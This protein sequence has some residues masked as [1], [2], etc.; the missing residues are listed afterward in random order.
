M[1]VVVAPCHLQPVE[2]LAEVGGFL[3]QGTFAG[4]TSVSCGT[5]HTAAVSAIG[6][7]Y[8]WGWG[9]HGQLVG[10][11]LSCVCVCVGGCGGGGSGGWVC[12]REGRARATRVRGA[13]IPPVC[14]CVL[15]LIARGQPDW[16]GWL[17]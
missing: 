16:C 6:D 10:A 8:T 2:A 9:K 3:P 1:V 11:W 12:M 14:A 15:C 5:W 4:V 17:R 13:C 7:L